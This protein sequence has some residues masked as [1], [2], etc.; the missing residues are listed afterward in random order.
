MSPVWIQ[1]ACNQ[2]VRH[3]KIPLQNKIFATMSAKMMGASISSTDSAALQFHNFV[4]VLHTISWPGDP[5]NPD[6][7][8]AL[9][10]KWKQIR[11]RIV[12]CDPWNGP[13]CL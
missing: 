1:T 13:G 4:D 6:G 9:C 8:I 2:K 12:L 5:L 3:L 10:A 7:H 11:M